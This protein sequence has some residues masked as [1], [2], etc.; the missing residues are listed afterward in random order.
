MA[1]SIDTPTPGGLVS[2]CIVSHKAY[3]AIRGG[4][5]GSVGGVEWQT[6]LLAKW[7]AGRGHAVSLATW[8]E[9]NPNTEIFD[10]VRVIKI[11]RPEAGLPGLRFF[12]PK[13]TGLN[14]ALAGADADVYYH[15]TAECVTGQIA[16]WCGRHQRKFVFSAACDTDCESSL[17]MLRKPWQRG[18]YRYGL[19]HAHAIIV[20]T[21]T[22]QRL[23]KD[24]FGLDSAVIPMPCPAAAEAGTVPEASR[25]SKRVLWMAR[26]CRQKR[27]DR[28]LDLAEGCPELAFDMA[29]PFYDDDYA[30]QAR[31]RASRISN[32]TVHG[33]VPR[34]RVASFYRNAACLCCT[35]D[36]EGF[37][38]TFLEAWSHGLPVVSTFDPDSIIARKKLGLVAKDVPEMREALRSLL[39]SPEQYLEISLNA[40]E[41]F[42]RNHELESVM[43]KFES[44][45]ASLAAARRRPP[46][47]CAP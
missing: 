43:P 15:N 25:K 2:V 29:G 38:N 46:T 8:D 20:Q 45:F 6:S 22:Q 19:R 47:P 9:G 35:S 23:L 7:L 40:R 13:W 1:N 36:F 24:G 39:A 34:E 32:V 37:P 30:R 14:R 17:G 3:G 11:C 21:D 5:S 4:Q 31:E 44:I 27:P 33:A 26:A 10:R 16:L 12:H 42:R 28:L 41:Y 18:L